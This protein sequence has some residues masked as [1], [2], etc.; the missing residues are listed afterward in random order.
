MHLTDDP[1]DPEFGRVVPCPAGCGRERAQARLE[2]ISGL[3][4]RQLEMSFE[5]VTWNEHQVQAVETLRRLTSANPPSGFVLLSGHFGVGKT[6]MLCATVNL[7]RR[8]G[9]T[10][11]YMTAEELLD[12]LRQGYDPEAPEGFDVLWRRVS[13]A[14]VL[15]ID[16][17][18]RINATSWAK[19]KMFQLLDD[20]YERHLYGPGA[21]TVMATNVAV[22]DLDGYLRSRLT[23]THSVC[24]SLWGAPD[25]RS[26]REQQ[27]V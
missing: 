24:L 8:V 11:V 3:R 26:V 15:A 1:R 21:L 16:E 13:D 19:A 2:A 18:D 22:E 6:H 9:R 25:M 5:D 10:A 17:V 4:G 23:D 7:A 14:D 12:R 20:R 27:P